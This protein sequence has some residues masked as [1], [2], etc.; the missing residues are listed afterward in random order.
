MRRGDYIKDLSGSYINFFLQ[1]IHMSIE[2]IVVATIISTKTTRLGLS[3]V[4]KPSLVNN[5]LFT[6][7]VL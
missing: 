1:N 6:S 2:N 5:I 3:E 4:L 7:L